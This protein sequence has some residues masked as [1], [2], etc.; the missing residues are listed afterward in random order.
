MFRSPD[1]ALVQLK[2]YK[3]RG[4]WFMSQVRQ[5]HFFCLFSKRIDISN[6]I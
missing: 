4:Q 3:P 5:V 6:D 2:D 1:K